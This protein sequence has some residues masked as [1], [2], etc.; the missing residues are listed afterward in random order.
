MHDGLCRS[1]AAWFAL[2]AGT[3]VAQRR[4]TL[5]AC[6]FHALGLTVAADLAARTAP[7]GYRTFFED[8]PDQRPAILAFADEPTGREVWRRYFWAGPAAPGP[9]APYTKVE[10][11]GRTAGPWPAR[12]VFAPDLAAL[13]RVERRST[14]AR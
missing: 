5:G 4:A 11:A 13:G 10:R 2:A 6:V 12:A 3:T 1:S 14:S 8:H 9:T 7:D